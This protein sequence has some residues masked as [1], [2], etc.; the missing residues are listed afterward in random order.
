[1]SNRRKPMRLGLIESNHCAACTKSTEVLKKRAEPAIPTT[2]LTHPTTDSVSK[3]SDAGKV[4]ALYQPPAAIT[5]DHP[6]D[7]C[8]HPRRSSQEKRSGGMGSRFA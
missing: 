4:A 3:A 8:N 2:A 5:R 6:I 7:S 1:M